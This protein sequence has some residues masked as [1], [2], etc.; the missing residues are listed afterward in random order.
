MRIINYENKAAEQFMASLAKRDPVAYRFI[1]NRLGKS[2]VG[3]L[4]GTW[5]DITSGITE[6]GT[7]LYNLYR[8]EKEAEKAAD[9]AASEAQVAL[10]NAQR[11][12]ELAQA[13]T[14]AIA[15]RRQLEQEKNAVIARQLE[16]E[17]QSTNKNRTM[18][19]IAAGLLSAILVVPRLI[20]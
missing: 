15:A 6:L 13:Q 8:N 12:I 17:A 11:E 10:L 3:S 14:Q 7:G 9:M 5:D 18:L 2:G 1:R 16:L 20:R 4:S 19:L